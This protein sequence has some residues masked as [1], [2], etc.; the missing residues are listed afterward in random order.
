MAIYYSMV[1]VILYLIQPDFCQLLFVWF[2]IIHQYKYHWVNTPLDTSLQSCL[3][4]WF[5]LLLFF[6]FFSCGINFLKRNP[7]AKDLKS[8]STLLTWQGPLGDP[9]NQILSWRILS[10]WWPRNRQISTT[11]LLMVLF[12]FVYNMQAWNEF[13]SGSFLWVIMCSLHQALPFISSSNKHLIK[14]GV[15]WKPYPC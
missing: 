11:V 3:C 15:T 4:V 9:S 7:W 8:F 2:P 10:M 12:H 5:F 14:A 1:W 13:L 6:F